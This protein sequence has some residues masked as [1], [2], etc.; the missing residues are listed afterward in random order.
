MKKVFDPFLELKAAGFTLFAAGEDWP[1]GYVTIV[2]YA[3]LSW[4]PLSVSRSRKTAVI[5][6]HPELAQLEPT[7][8]EIM[9]SSFPILIWLMAREP[10]P[11]PEHCLASGGKMVVGRIE[12]GK[13]PHFHSVLSAAQASLAEGRPTLIE[14]VEETRPGAP[15]GVLSIHHGAHP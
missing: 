3:L 14:S 8:A 5:L 9:N 2:P 6:D 7:V 13:Q 1:K 12:T 15:F 4:L 10:T 11:W